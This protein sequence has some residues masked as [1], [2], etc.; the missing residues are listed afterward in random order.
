M[1]IIILF[2]ILS[3]IN[4]IL[5][6]IRSITT[7]KCGKYVAS[8]IS[9]IYF[10]F[11][12]V[13]VIYTVADFDLW[14]KIAITFGTNLIG[15]F[16]VKLIEEKMRKDKLWKV[17]TAIRNKDVENVADLLKKAKVPFNSVKTSR[18]YTI[19]NIF[20]ATQ[21]QSSAVKEILIGYNAK[22]F[23]SESKNL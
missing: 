13:M 21:T 10:G 7:I 17:E 14:A 5:S 20:C 3:V 1:N 23:V 15:V 4:V 12:T 2:I 16:V 22:Y 19:F 9:A 18:N 8:L 6:T 11:Y